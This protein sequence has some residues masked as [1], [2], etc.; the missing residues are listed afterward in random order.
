[1]LTFQEL[2]ERMGDRLDPDELVEIL[3]VTSTELIE[4]FEYKIEEQLDK[5]MN[6][7]GDPEES[8]E[9]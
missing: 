9:T 6:D 1:M 8:D 5:F 3:G 2:K 4:A 7:Y